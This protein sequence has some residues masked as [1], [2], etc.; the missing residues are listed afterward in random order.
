MPQTKSDGNFFFTRIGLLKQLWLSIATWLKLLHDWNS[1]THRRGKFAKCLKQIDL[2]HLLP[3]K[4]SLCPAPIVT[5][6]LPRSV[7]DEA[8]L[9]EFSKFKP[10][11]HVGLIFVWCAVYAHVCNFYLETMKV[12]FW[13]GINYKKCTNYSS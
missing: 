13:V 5:K 6:L 11:S 4:C 2:K 7:T 1:T 12:G 8:L 9:C 3:G 10:A